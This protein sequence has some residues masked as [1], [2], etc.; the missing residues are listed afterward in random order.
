VNL[1]SSHRVLERPDFAAH[2][3]CAYFGVR[4]PETPRDAQ[5]PNCWDESWEENAILAERSIEIVPVI[6]TPLALPTEFRR[7][8]IERPKTLP[9]R[10]QPHHRQPLAALTNSKWNAY[11]GESPCDPDVA[12]PCANQTQAVAVGG[13]S[14]TRRQ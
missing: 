7:S 14:V 3:H 4:R 1:I 13:S 10:H 9:D 6:P 5:G 8:S 2:R 11:A 12:A